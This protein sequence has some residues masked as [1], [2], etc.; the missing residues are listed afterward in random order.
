[1]A[2]PSKASRVAKAPAEPAA[3]AAPT[4]TPVGPTPPVAAAPAIGDGR[5]AIAANETRIAAEAAQA[6]AAMAAA[7]AVP[8]PPADDSRPVSAPYSPPQ[9]PPE[10]RR[11]ISMNIPE[12]LKEWTE[13]FAAYHAGRYQRL[14]RGK[15]HE[16]LLLHGVGE[17]GVRAVKAFIHTYYK[18]Y[19]HIG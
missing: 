13:A 12:S 3:P 8:N 15:V 7:Q 9:G 16:L 19:P 1:M 2:V 14:D 18:P 17:D 5:A 6:A 10:V 11:V 4:V